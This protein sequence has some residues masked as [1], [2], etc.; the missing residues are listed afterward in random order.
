MRQHVGTGSEH[1]SETVEVGDSGGS[2]ISA[3]KVPETMFIFTSD[4]CGH[5]E[6]GRPAAT[7][8]S[9]GLEA[10]AGFQF[11]APAAAAKTCDIAFHLAGIWGPKQRV[12]SSCRTAEQQKHSTG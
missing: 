9:L 6:C 12:R 4:A 11:L 1:T 2:S 8:V 10:T 7:K 5:L 3:E